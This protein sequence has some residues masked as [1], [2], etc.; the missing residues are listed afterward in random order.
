MSE[1]KQVV[2][3]IDRSLYD[4]K[5]VETDAEFYLTGDPALKGLIWIESLLMSDINLI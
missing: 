2:A 4:F 3:D 1:N 5:D